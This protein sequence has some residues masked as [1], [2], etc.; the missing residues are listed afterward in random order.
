LLDAWPAIRGA[1]PEAKLHIYYGRETFGQLKDHELKSLVI[2]I[3]ALVNSGVVEKGR[4][5]HDELAKALNKA[6]LLCAESQF[7]E[8]YGIVH[9]KSVA[10]GVIPVVTDVIDKALVPAEIKL[11]DHTSP[12]LH[13]DFTSLVI[14]RLTQAKNLELEDLRR[15]CIKYG[16]ANL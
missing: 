13:Q 9:A 11:L 1:H 7:N 16:K 5:S 15:T 3:E 8:T 10:A 12:T 2:K 4:V 6:S 14:K